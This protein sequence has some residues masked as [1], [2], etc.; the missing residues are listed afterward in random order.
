MKHGVR[1]ISSC[2]HEQTIVKVYKYDGLTTRGRAK[3][4]RYTGPSAACAALE[5]YWG[6]LL[7]PRR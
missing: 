3:R 6:R 4:K 5:L 7:P 2:H 1:D